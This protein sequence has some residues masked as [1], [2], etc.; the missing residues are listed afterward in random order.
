MPE[1]KRVFPRAIRSIAA[2]YARPGG[3][4]PCVAIDFGVQGACLEMDEPF[5]QDEVEVC[6]ELESDWVVRT[7]ARKVWERQDN[8]RFF[9]GIT[10][11][12]LRS[13]DKSL[14]GPWIHKMRKAQES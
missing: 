6:F 8:D 3:L 12:P 11:K 10:Y 4:Q 5:P 7:R 14:I 13:S 9:V 2:Y 1:H